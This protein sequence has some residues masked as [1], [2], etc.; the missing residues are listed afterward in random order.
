MFTA[1]ELFCGKSQRERSHGKKKQMTVPSRFSP[2]FLFYTNVH[3]LTD[4]KNKNKTK[5]NQTQRVAKGDRPQVPPDTPISYEMLMSE[6]W[7]H[8]AEN[9]PSFASI[10]E[11]LKRWGIMEWVESLQVGREERKE[12]GGGKKER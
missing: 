8:K 2:L 9:R 1:T 5:T 4:K 11:Q 3:Q 7:S 10:L 12:K 6:C